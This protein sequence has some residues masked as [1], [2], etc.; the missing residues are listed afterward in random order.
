M[1]RIES[2][3]VQAKGQEIAVKKVS[4]DA[5]KR[6]DGDNFLHGF[7]LITLSVAGDAA[8]TRCTGQN[9]LRR[10]TW[11]TLSASSE[12]VSRRLTDVFLKARLPSGDEIARQFM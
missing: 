6:C 5:V 11:I 2:S 1:S 7:P 8:V 9:L 12:T 4:G 10:C 3:L